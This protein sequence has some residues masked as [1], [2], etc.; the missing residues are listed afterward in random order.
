MPYEVPGRADEL[1]DDLVAAW[2]G[3]IEEKFSQQDRELRESRFFALDIEQL[4]EPTETRGVKWTG[5][6]AEPRFCLDDETVAQEL[7]DWGV[8]GRHV[9]HN[10]YC[11]Y[12]V[13]MRADA[14]GKLRP[15]RV[16][17][18]TELREYWI[19]VAKH[20]PERVRS[21]AT[22]VF[23][24]EVAFDELFEIDD[25]L[26]LE[27]DAREIA[28]AHAVAGN[29]GEARL[30]KA[31]V[32]AQPR[33]KLNTERA[34]FMTHPINGL[35]DLLFIVMF[36]ARPYAKRNQDQIDPA[37]R[38]EIFT[39]F[40]SPTLA[41]R[42]ADPA[43]AL[44][45]YGVA[46]QGGQVGFANPLGMYMREPNFSVFSFQGQAVPAGWIQLG[47]GEAGAWQR[48]TFGPRDEEEAFLDDITVSVGASDRPLRG[49]YQLLQHVDVGPLVLVG[50]GAPPADDE[51]LFVGGVEPIVC[52]DSS[53]CAEIQALK[54]AFDAEQRDRT[55]PRVR[56]P[57]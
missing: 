55:A 49:G 24:R 51:W 18:T 19:C 52:G 9:L 54:E 57:Q 27:P 1:D 56:G 30:Q 2:N 21:M 12:S 10:E 3:T 22:E 6:P 47:R 39:T 46:F 20:D 32:Q 17:V 42:H 33:G 14:S 38:D 37:S 35:D 13:L 44:G 16:E 29:G 45:A 31:G 25:P 15:K 5:D 7:C 34:L 26:A 50:T 43:A 36:G 8:L 11:E 48:L 23:G 40:S 53:A 41:C 28:F 4:V